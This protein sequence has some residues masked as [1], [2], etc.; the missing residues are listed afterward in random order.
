[1]IVWID[2]DG[3][4]R[5]IRE[6]VFKRC[7]QKRFFVKCVANRYAPNPPGGL[8]EM[9]VSSSDFDASDQYIVD[10][11]DP[12]DIVITNDVL[13]ADLIVSSGAVA[14]SPFGRLFDASSIKEQLMMR[15]LNNEMRSA[16]VVTGRQTGFNQKDVQ[17]FANVFDRLIQEKI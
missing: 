9:I 4:P 8:I 15:N 3:C 10:H 16:G 1:M 17:K 12:K 2:N 14:V 13:L 7:E 11:V 5:K 6:M